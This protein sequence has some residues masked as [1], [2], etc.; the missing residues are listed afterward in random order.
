MCIIFQS[1]T[2]YN[3]LI[4]LFGP[5]YIINETLMS[6][7]WLKSSVKKKKK[8]QDRKSL[9]TFALIQAMIVSHLD[10]ISCIPS[11]GS[12]K[13]T[14]DLLGW[15]LTDRE[16]HILCSRLHFISCSQLMTKY[17]KN[18]KTGPLSW[19][20]L[21]PPAGNF[22]LSWLFRNTPIVEDF[23]YTGG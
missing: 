5:N 20:M 13:C 1:L 17:S 2:C 21:N 18:T 3:I 10:S 22:G 11:V 19:D 16:P 4:K 14:L 12:W 9:G 15:N 6:F 8:N 7:F 23:S